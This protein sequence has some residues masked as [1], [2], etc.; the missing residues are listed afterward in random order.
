MIMLEKLL[1]LKSVTFFKQTPDELLME[2][3]HSALQEIALE[4]GQQVIQ[5]GEVGNAMYVIVNGRV[6]IHDGDLLIGE[7]GEREIFGELAA[8]SF[9]QRVS[10]VSAITDCLLLK[11]SSVALYD[12][13]TLDIGLAKGIIKALCERTQSMSLQLQ[14]LLQNP[15]ARE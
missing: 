2:I 12:M 9:G 14:E 7:L 6:K 5:K 11:I 1:L 15:G 4:S 3:A 8:L 13:M 10:C